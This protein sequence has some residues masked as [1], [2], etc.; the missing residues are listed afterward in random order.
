MLVLHARTT[1]GPVQT[2]ACRKVAWMGVAHRGRSATL[3][4]TRHFVTR[5]RQRASVVRSTTTPTAASMATVITDRATALSPRYVLWL[6]PL[7]CS[8]LPPRPR[9][10]LP[11][12]KGT[13]VCAPQ[14][15]SPPPP[16][17]SSPPPD[18]VPIPVPVPVASPPPTVA[19]SPP[20]PPPNAPLYQAI[21]FT[22]NGGPR[23]AGFLDFPSLDKH[24]CGL[25]RT[26]ALDLTCGDRFC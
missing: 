20:P 5:F 24:V 10:G 3:Q 1:L 14:P 19:V 7:H 12:E 13:D 18:P 6:A 17:R 4:G 2:Y 11:P 21:S 16:R 22:L 8:R 23:P 15:Q 9:A 25:L 26:P